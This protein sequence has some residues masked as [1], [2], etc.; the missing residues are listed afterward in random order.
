[1]VVHWRRVTV[2]FILA[3]LVSLPALATTEFTLQLRW[4]HQFQFAGYYMA[5]EKGY[6]EEA[7]LDVTLREGGEDTLKP[8][9]DVLTGEA[10]FAISNSGVVIQY[11][12][13]QPVVALAAIMQTSP[14]AWIVRKDS[15]IFSPLDLAGKR[16]ML[17]P[18]PES[19]ELLA[20]LRREGIN[21]DE[22]ELIPTTLDINDLVR[23]EVDAYD[24][25]ATNEP[26]HLTEQGVDYRLIRP[27]DYG[28]NFYNDVLIADEAL[29]EEKPH[30]VAAFV[31]ASLRGWRYA[32]ENIEESV[33]LIRERYAVEK[34]R[35]HLLFE[36]REMKS[37][38][39]PELVELGHMNPARWESI[40]QDYVALGLAEG[41]IDLS[42]F[43]Y[44][45]EKSQD[46]TWIYRIVTMTVLG[47]LAVSFVA[48]R[49]ANLNRKLLK[50]AA[51][52]ETIET[53]LREKQSELYRLANT[54]Q[55]TGVWNRLKF[56]EVAEE[57][58]Q[59]CRRYQSPLSLLYVDL[60]HFKEI[61]DEHGHHVGDA[62]LSGVARLLDRKLRQSDRLFRWG[63]EEFLILTPHIDLEQAC[64]LAEKLRRLI[65]SS[66]LYGDISVSASLGVATLSD[67]D[68]LDALIRRADEALYRA[69]ERGRNTV[70]REGLGNAG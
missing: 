69:K 49:F 31:D 17:M 56:E 45:R 2:L 9:D 14:M 50:E 47:L 13:G 5:Q 66:A 6:Y 58:L 33:D 37:L 36:A 46:L 67:D 26:Y 41:P 39:M 64:I 7:G 16:L 24:G 42:S 15:S 35:A 32:L 70:V 12:A 34:S 28:V 27:G 53:Q 18:P 63:G 52:R 8:V 44:Q 22:L 4:F 10:D 20:M 43:L 1:M 3:H 54:D 21:L 38:I 25:Y 68:S 19:A 23:G 30:K 40:A 57:E 62:I 55:L 59:R 61:N 65:A 51:A 48:M 11:M 29:V 60:D